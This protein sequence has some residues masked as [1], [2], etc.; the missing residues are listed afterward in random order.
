MKTTLLTGLTLILASTVACAQPS[1]DGCGEVL[2]FGLFEEKN[3]TTELATMHAARSLMCKASGSRESRTAEQSESGL[4]RDFPVLAQ[5]AKSLRL[6]SNKEAFDRFCSAQHSNFQLAA[7]SKEYSRTASA[8]IVSAWR[9]CK[10]RA[11]PRGSSVYGESRPGSVRV[12]ARYAT[13]EV[14]SRRD[15]TINALETTP[16][17]SCQSS[18]SRLKKVQQKATHSFSCKRTSNQE[19]KIDLEINGALHSVQ[20]P[21]I[22]P[23]EVDESCIEADHKGCRACALPLSDTE[24]VTGAMKAFSCRA[25]APGQIRAVSQINVGLTSGSQQNSAE[26][27]LSHALRSAKVPVNWKDGVPFSQKETERHQYAMDSPHQIDVRH[28]TNPLTVEYVVKALQ[29]KSPSNGKC[30]LVG[31]GWPNAESIGSRAIIYSEP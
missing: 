19:Q 29:C 1:N 10:T 9:D 8:V 25:M 26:I 15:W 20:F 27:Q 5:Y 14:G 2:K 3:S 16:G 21:Q 7:S 17:L 23:R 30:Q 4:F 12:T 11:A 31:E 18:Q 6:S 22:I 24:L 28:V 13:D